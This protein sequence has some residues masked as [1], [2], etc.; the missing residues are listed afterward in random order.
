V[1]Y[2]NTRRPGSVTPAAHQQIGV[3]PGDRPAVAPD[4][5]DVPHA[6]V[7]GARGAEQAHP[8]EHLGGGAA[9][10]DLVTA[11]AQGRGPLDDRGAEAVPVQLVGQGRAGEAGTADEYLAMRHAATIQTSYTFV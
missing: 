2:A 1:L 8:L 10:V 11:V 5:G 6:G 7:G 4:V 9:D 3:E